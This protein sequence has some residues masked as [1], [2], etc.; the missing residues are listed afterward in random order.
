M[1]TGPGPCRRCRPLSAAAQ[2]V[3]PLL[4]PEDPEL[5]MLGQGW[6]EEPPD[7]GLVD[8]LDGPDAGV[9]GPVVGPDDELPDDELPDDELVVT[10]V[11]AGVLCV[12]ALA[13]ARPAPKLRPKAPP[14]KA[15]VTNG[16]LSCI[17]R[18]FLHMCCTTTADRAN[19][20]SCSDL[21]WRLGNVPHISAVQVKA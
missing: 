6:S 5:P 4:L 3:V 13:T 10:A 15:R 12:V 21:P 16:F 2:P 18:S 1:A 9:D 20:G 8:G 11:V 7:G 14:A 17:T 19:L